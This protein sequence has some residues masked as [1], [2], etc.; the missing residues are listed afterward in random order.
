MSTRRLA[1]V[2][3]MTAVFSGAGVWL[4]AAGITAA[5]DLTGYSLP[6]FITSLGGVL[7]GLL[8]TIL[9]VTAA[10]VVAWPVV[11]RHARSHSWVS[12]SR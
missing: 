8:W 2:Y 10:A 1:A 5:A 3:L 11:L 7:A 12:S 4:F 6:L 9:A